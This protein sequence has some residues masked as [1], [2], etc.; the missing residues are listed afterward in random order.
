MLRTYY[1]LTKPGI[2]RANAITAL[3]GF[4]FA[5]R[6]DVDMPKLIA[7]VIG[8]A[9]VVAC[10]CVLNN[11]V[12]RDI[13]KKMKRTRSRALVTGSVSL[14]AALR[15]AGVLGVAGL[16]I[17]AIFTNLLTVLIGILAVFFYVVVYGWAKRNTNYATEVGT[18]P[19]A[20]SIVA[21]YTA[22][23]GRLDAVAFGLFLVL[24]M[25]QLPHF[26][27]ITIFRADEYASAKIKVL[28]H[29][30]GIEATQRRVLWGILGFVMSSI[31]LA[32]Y[33]SPSLTYL[34][35]VTGAGIYWLYNGLQGYQMTEPVKWARKMFGYSLVVLLLFSI[36]ISF[37][38]WLP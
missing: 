6:G 36:I 13:D 25:W 34:F 15:Y 20:A 26:W 18:L 19:G 14:Q 37:D 1:Q 30:K 10:G 21:G 16:F 23:T 27:A 3:A 9:L 4:M 8:T 17:L 12:D 38:Y 24:V 28:P 7:T 35:V 31:V 5:S 22:V 29:R 2:V 33:S 32:I 11:Y